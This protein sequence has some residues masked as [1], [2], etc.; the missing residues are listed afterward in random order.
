MQHAMIVR[1]P[2]LPSLCLRVFLAGCVLSLVATL[3]A[4]ASNV[5]CAADLDNSGA[6]DQPNEVQQCSNFPATPGTTTCQST[7]IQCVSGT[8]TNAVGAGSGGGYSCPGHPLLSCSV[9]PGQSGEYCSVPS[10]CT[11]TGSTPGGYLCPLQTQACALDSTGNYA[12]PLGTGYACIQPGSGAQPICSAHPCADANGAGVVTTPNGNDPLPTSTGP[13]AADGSCLGVLHI[14]PGEKSTCKGSG[15]ETEFQD[16]C[17]GAGKIG[18]TM[19]KKGSNTQKDMLY[20]AL[21]GLPIIIPQCSSSDTQ[22]GTL[23]ESGYCHYVGDY[24]GLDIPLVGCVQQVHSYCCF[25]SELSRIVQ[26][27]GRPQLPEMGGWGSAKSP[28]CAGFTPAEF[29]SLDFSKI[30]LSE[31]Y[32]ELQYDS[33]AQIESQVNTNALPH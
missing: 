17:K 20:S 28:N 11:T 8:Q 31:Y 4:Q 5:E 12:C 21:L 2:Q 19:G 13:T 9:Q 26:E 7:L 18:D 14:F 23:R 1:A 22:T 30:D 10:N 24:C 3:Q 33:Q 29:Q 25:D 6:I 15:V 27:Q 16:C 32:T